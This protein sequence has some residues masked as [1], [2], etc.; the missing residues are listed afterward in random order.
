MKS[1]KVTASSVAMSSASV[2][3]HTCINGQN[4]QAQSSTEAELIAAE[5]AVTIVPSAETLAQ[6]MGKRVGDDIH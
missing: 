3:D 2:D 5:E 6:E 1:S 4:I